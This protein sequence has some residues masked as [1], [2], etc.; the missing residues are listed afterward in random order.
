MNN[1]INQTVKTQSLEKFQGNWQV[2]SKE[3]NFTADS[4]RAQQLKP[5]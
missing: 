1:Y 4:C 3:D 5:I 2:W